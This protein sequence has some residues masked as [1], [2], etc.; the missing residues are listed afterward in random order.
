MTTIVR[1]SK[2]PDEIRLSLLGKAIYI[3]IIKAKNNHLFHKI[4]EALQEEFTELRR[5]AC[6]LFDLV[7]EGDEDFKNLTDGKNGKKLFSEWMQ[8]GL[9]LSGPITPF[10]L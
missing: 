3:S 4:L 2:T 5:E 7:W 1:E 9:G 8:E 6:G 10:L